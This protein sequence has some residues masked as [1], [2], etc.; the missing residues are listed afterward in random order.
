MPLVGK[1]VS[2]GVPEHVGMRLG[3]R[4][5]SAAALSIMRAKPAVVMGEPRSLTNTKGE[6]AL[7]RRSRRR[8][9]SSSPWIG[10]VLG[11]PFLTRRTCSTAPLKST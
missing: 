1:G 3:S 11:V 8:A 5:A 9:R 7:S 10:W 2:A 6:A 4:P